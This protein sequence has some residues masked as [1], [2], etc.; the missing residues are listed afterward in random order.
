MT[1]RTRFPLVNAILTAA[2][3]LLVIFLLTVPRLF[4]FQVIPQLRSA[5]QEAEQALLRGEL[6][7]VDAAMAQMCVDFDA[8]EQRLKLFLNHEEVDEFHASLHA[9]RDLALI[10]ERGNFLS[11]LQDLLRILDYWEGSETLNIYNLF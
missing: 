8:V 9:A 1:R 11:E 6:N 5:A 10:D 7:T 4:L 3:A 2:A